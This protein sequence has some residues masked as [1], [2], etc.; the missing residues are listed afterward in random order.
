[1]LKYVNIYNEYPT[2]TQTNTEKKTN[3]EW[4]N[5]IIGFPFQ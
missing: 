5:M 2:P 4:I 3:S 1:M